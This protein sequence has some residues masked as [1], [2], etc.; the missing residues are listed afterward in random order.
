[1]AIEQ[2]DAAP[3]F[4]LPDDSGGTTSLGDFAGS[5][6][7]LYFYPKAFTPGCTTQA[8]D[9]RDNHAAFQKA[10]YRIVGVSPDAPDRLAKFKAKHKLPFTLVSDEDHGVAE[11][12]GAWGTKK[13]YG[14]EYEGLIRS[15]FIV[16]ET[17]TVQTAWR[18]VRATGHGERVMKETGVE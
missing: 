9:F 16:D 2:G 5:K 11:A 15:T 12:Y 7:I 10:G 18:N 6:L 3:D 1:M 14:R 17:G 13:N 8:C 4:S